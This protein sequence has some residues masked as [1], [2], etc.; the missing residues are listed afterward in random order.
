M[1]NDELKTLKESLVSQ[2]DNALAAFQQAVGAIQLI[3][4]LLEKEETDARSSSNVN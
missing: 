3:D 2:R 4:H 1:T